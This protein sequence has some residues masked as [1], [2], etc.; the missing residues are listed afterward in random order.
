MAQD[1]VGTGGGGSTS[2]TSVALNFSNLNAGG[3]DF[4]CRELMLPI[5]S[6]VEDVDGT[7]QR[8]AQA[9]NKP[10]VLR[11]SIGGTLYEF[12]VSNVDRTYAFTSGPLNGTT[13]RCVQVRIDV[14]PSN[15]PTLTKTYE[16]LVAFS[17]MRSAINWSSVNGALLYP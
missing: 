17:A 12:T 1:P 5:L 11:R 4:R 8:F 14:V 6:A 13:E 15:S 9:S 7:T 3:V 2:L 10:N 16:F